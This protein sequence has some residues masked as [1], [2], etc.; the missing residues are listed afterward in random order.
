MSVLTIG[1][2]PRLTPRPPGPVRGG[3]AS[4]QVRWIGSNFGR[5]RRILTLV[6]ALGLAGS[7]CSSSRS[8][9]EYAE[10]VE[11]LVA[12]MN[13]RI[14]D[15]EAEVAA[16]PTLERA[17]SYA[18]DR[19]D[20]R[21]DFIDALDALE[22][23]DEVADLHTTALDIF[24]RLVAAETVLADLVMV[25]ES[26]EEADA[27]W[28]TPQGE[29]FRRID[30]EA[31]ALCAV[32]QADVDATQQRDVFSDMPWIPPEMKEVIDVAFRCDRVD[33]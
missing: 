3:S 14:D 8:L 24:N 20:A 15:G 12:T 26:F 7:A 23:P 5:V 19:L 28:I 25:A 4:A 17:Q 27:V 13:Q 29:A 31:V 18:T 16:D 32:V 10:E 6:V 21:H 30:E 2:S 9:G 22:P 33:R 11:R 1:D